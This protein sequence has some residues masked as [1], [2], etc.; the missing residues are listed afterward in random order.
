LKRLI[1]V[2]P[3]LG[4]M[5]AGCAGP[6]A[7]GPAVDDPGRRASLLKACERPAATR[8][9]FQ[10]VV[11]WPGRELSLTEIVKRHPDGGYSVAGVSDVGSTLYAARV[12]DDGRGEIVSK[13][14][15][16][17]DRWLLEGFVAELLVPW[18]RPDETSQLHETADG[19]FA[20]VQNEERLR[21]VYLFD[22]SGQWVAYRRLAGSRQR[23][24]VSLEWSA[25]PLPTTMRVENNQR[26][27]RAVRENV[28][29]Q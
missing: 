9:V 23:Y 8:G 6:R 13:S 11:R 18:S 22:A 17:S 2:I 7:L 3:I 10:T 1:A 5:V 29:T 27:Y 25:G 24:E 14:L 26:H 4:L 20:L 15:P 28:S 21:H 12:T 16:F 19:T